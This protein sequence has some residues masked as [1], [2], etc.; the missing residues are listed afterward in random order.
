MANKYMKYTNMGPNKNAKQQIITNRLC[1]YLH[2]HEKRNRALKKEIRIRDKYRKPEL[3]T[4]EHKEHETSPRIMHKTANELNNEPDRTE[5]NHQC[6][7][8]MKYFGIK[9]GRMQHQRMSTTGQIQHNN[10][11][12]YPYLCPNDKRS[13]LFTTKAKMGKHLL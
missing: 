2:G 3:L 6:S 11:T 5:Q 12:I 4:L 9:R 7:T 13:R 1:D 8:C 10:T